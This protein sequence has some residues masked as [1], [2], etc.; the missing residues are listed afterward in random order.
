MWRSY[1]KLGNRS[2]VLRWIDPWSA[3]CVPSYMLTA[4]LWTDAQ[5]FLIGG[6]RPNRCGVPHIPSVPLILKT[7]FICKLCP[8]WWR[9]WL[10]T[11]ATNS[12]F[13]SVWAVMTNSWA[14]I[15][16]SGM[17]DSILLVFEV[18]FN[19]TLYSRRWVESRVWDFW[20]QF[21]CLNSY[22]ALQLWKT[23]DLARRVVAVKHLDLGLA[24]GVGSVLA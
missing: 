7:L 5:E 1:S 14:G 22:W 9:R 16:L 2:V 17:H 8:S 19:S 12:F 11:F 23:L 10:G 21:S 24:E 3:K 13:W 20:I 6:R 4:L 18:Y 15:L